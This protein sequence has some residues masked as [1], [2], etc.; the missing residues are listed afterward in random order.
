MPI[1]PAE[2]SIFP[3]NLFAEAGA[4][5]PGLFWWCLHTKPRQ[6]K[7]TARFLR[8]RGLPHFLP[9]M[10]RKGQ[11]PKGRKRT[12]HAPLFPSYLF[13]LGDPRDRLEAFQGHTLVNIL[14]IGDQEQIENDL[15]QIVRMLASGLP[16]APELNHPVGSR[17]RILEGP[18]EGLVGTV[19]QQGNRDRFVTLVHFLGQG[20]TVELQGWQIERLAG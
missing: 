3:E 10:T 5:P 4:R 6:E 14:E 19:V 12:S 17:V 1:R 20:A 2:P 18:L 8:E 9:Q 15:R 16:V 13:L 11:T 7:A